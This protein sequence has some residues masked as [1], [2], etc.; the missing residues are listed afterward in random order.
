MHLNKILIILPTLLAV[1]FIIL[2][3]NDNLDELTFADLLH[4]FAV[5]LPFVLFFSFI[6]KLI[7]KNNTKSVLISSFLIMLFFVYI[8]LHNALYEFQIGRHMILLPIISICSLIGIIFFIKSKKNFENLLKITSIPV[9][10]LIIFNIGEISFYSDIYSYSVND[11]LIQFFSIDKKDY[12]DVYHIILDEHAS[13]AAL[14]QYLNYNNS[15]F[16]NSLQNMGFFIPEES[17]SN[18]LPSA[19]SIPSIL[20]MDYTDY[21][22][23]WG[24]KEESVLLDKMMSN[25]VVTKIFE[26]NGYEII[27]FYNEL[28]MKPTIDSSNELC[29]N[30]IGGAQFL[31]FILDNTPIIFVKNLID[32]GNYAEIA[33]N[34]LCVFNEL[35]SLDKKFSHPMF[36]YAHILSPHSPYVFSSDGNI[37]PYKKPIPLDELDSLYLSQLEYIDSLVLELVEVLLAKEPQPII[38]I[39]SDHGKDG[40]L[41]TNKGI[42]QS[43]SNFIA[44]Y[45]P[46]VELKQINYPLLISVNSFRILFNNNFGTDYELL[47]NKMYVIEDNKFKDVTNIVISNNT[48]N[49]IDKLY[50]N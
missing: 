36:V 40:D 48:F 49:K 5:I 41:D 19:I 29:N 17:F 28:D 7:I 10:V 35:K 24:Q 37:V 32:P 47:E 13:M 8:P 6:M 4:P 2:R 21:D 12:R 23:Q 26:K 1:Y 50:E 15:K 20:N 46:D 31:T 43:F 45:F 11:N 44:Y 16:D 30:S 25:N 18:Y 22:F 33:E 27:Y 9:L 42:R 34:R 14:Q 39:Q 3:Y 38:I